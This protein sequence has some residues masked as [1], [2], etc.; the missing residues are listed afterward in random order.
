MASGR[1]PLRSIAHLQAFNLS[2]WSRFSASFA[3]SVRLKKSLLCSRC[4]MDRIK[5]G[6]VLRRSN[7]GG[8]F[9][10]FTMT[11]KR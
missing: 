10:G 4:H 5:Y 11:G 6:D 2:E 7:R 9:E 1:W 3:P 8:K